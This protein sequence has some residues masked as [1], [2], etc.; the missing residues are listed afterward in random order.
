MELKS[1]KGWVVY[2]SNGEVF[3]LRPLLVD[4]G[5]ITKQV[6]MFPSVRTQA[7]IKQSGGSSGFVL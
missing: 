2:N 7:Q 3:I 5:C 4:R 1:I 6:S